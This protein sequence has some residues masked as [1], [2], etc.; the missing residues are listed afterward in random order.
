MTPILIAIN[1]LAF[2]LQQ[3]VGDVVV[4]RSALWPLGSGMFMP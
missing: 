2:V 4:Q 3:M 1:L